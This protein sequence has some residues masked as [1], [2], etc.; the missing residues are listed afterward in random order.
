[1]TSV[2]TLPELEAQYLAVISE[3]NKLEL[4]KSYIKDALLMLAGGK[5]LMGEKLM[6]K[7]QTRQGT[8]KYKEIPEVSKLDKSYLD[9]FRGE[10]KVIP[11]IK[12]F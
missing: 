3:L 1:M 11:L 8:I 10:T 7:F 9:K 6:V 4:R 5:E 2:H 12:V